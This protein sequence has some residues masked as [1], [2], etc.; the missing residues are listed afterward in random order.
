MVRIAYHY[1]RQTSNDRDGF[2]IPSQGKR[3]V[4][5][6]GHPHVMRQVRGA[7]PTRFPDER[8]DYGESR[9]ITVGF[10]RDRMVIIVWTSHRDARHIISMRKANE[11]E[12]TKYEGRLG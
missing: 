7:Y 5:S 2:T 11:R 4:G 8:K 6:L 3:L 12:I 10:L 9:N 1:T